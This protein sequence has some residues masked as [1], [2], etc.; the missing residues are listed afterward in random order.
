MS[1]SDSDF[2]SDQPLLRHIINLII[3]KKARNIAA[4]D[5]RGISS[6]TDFFVICNGESDPQVKAICDNIRK[7]TDHKPRYI[8]G[9]E[10]QNWVLLDYFDIIVHVFNKD[11]RKYYNLER[12]WADAPIIKVDDIE[13]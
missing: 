12:L 8:E 2:T 10:S 9:Y 7:G 6:F 11:E 5:V 1:K 4:M 3:E 13:S